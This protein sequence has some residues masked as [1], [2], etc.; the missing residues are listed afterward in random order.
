MLQAQILH[1]YVKPPGP[2]SHVSV[3]HTSS[4]TSAALRPGAAPTD[5]TPRHHLLWV[6]AGGQCQPAGLH[7]CDHWYPVASYQYKA[8]GT[9]QLLA[10][11]YLMKQ[12]QELGTDRYHTVQLGNRP[13]SHISVRPQLLALKLGLSNSLF[14]YA[15]AQ[16]TPPG[17]HQQPAGSSS[18]DSM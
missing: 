1:Q 7:T 14:P 4:R 18:L 10:A 15:G 13:E 12:Q 6:R 2:T 17:T 5:N 16:D 11:V 8:S 3:E 9:W